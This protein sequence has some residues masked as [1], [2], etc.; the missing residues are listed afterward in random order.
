MSSAPTRNAGLL[1]ALACIAQFMVVLDVAIV[2]V[3]LPSIQSA[4]GVTQTDL[5]WIIVGY[6]LPF[7]GF[8]LLGGRL[9]DLLGR[10]RVLVTGLALFALASLVAGLADSSGLL[11]AARV[12]QGL[13]AAL[14]PPAALSIIAVTFDEGASRNRAIGLFG[15][16]S[17]IAGTVGVVAS[18]ILTD[19]IGWRSIF[20]INLPIGI[21][22]IVAA[23]VGLRG[24]VA[25]GRPDARFDA[26][27]AVVGTLAL[28]ALI[29]G[30]NRGAGLGW[31]SPW[32]LGSLAV[33]AALVVVFIAIER[34]SADPLLPAVALRNRTLIGANLAAFFTFGAFFAFIFL[35]SL[36]MQQVLH[37]TPTQA[38][39]AWLA[40]TATSFV[41]AA[42]TGGKL[43]G[44][45]G[46]RTLLII[47]QALLAVAVLLLTSVAADATYVANI[48]PAFLLAGIA[49]GIAAP[50]AQIGAL[51]SIAREL[52]GTASGLVETLR[53]LGGAIGVAMVASLL[54]ASNGGIAGFR[55]GFWGIVATATLGMVVTILVLPRRRT[56]TSSNETT[57]SL[58]ASEK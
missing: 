20:L 41:A 12:V 15:A 19:G 35:G 23:I 42:V 39:L 46:V 37:F 53:E 54:I 40:T 48:L 3:A 55:A 9:T 18:G 4:L 31:L 51:S 49:G 32:A 24:D 27:G 45:L 30:V 50:A 25:V 36:L 52:T 56:A 2:N 29:F 33:G 14:V 1:L 58:A 5:Q 57:E 43:V 47:G 44:V 6:A 7:G 10:R 8:L 17:G 26:A 13:G 22:L 11:I 34:R 28:L 38:G 21:V 16:V